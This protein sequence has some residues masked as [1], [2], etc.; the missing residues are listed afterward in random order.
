MES[1][2]VVASFLACWR[3]QDLE[4]ALAHLDDEIVYTLHNGPDAGV[5]AGIH[6]GIEDC[7]RLGYAV[8]AEFDYLHYVPTIVGVRQTVVRAHVEFQIRH[9]QTGLVVEGTQRSVFR[10]RDGRIVTIDI[11]ED[12]ARMETFMKLLAQRLAC[13]RGHRESRFDAITQRIRSSIPQREPRGS[14]A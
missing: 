7:R 6:R 14:K 11:F 1:R 4:M 8:L 9:R 12:A 3:V 13:A 2:D 10:V 5:F